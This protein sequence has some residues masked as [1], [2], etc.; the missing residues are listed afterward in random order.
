MGGKGELVQYIRLFKKGPLKAADKKVLKEKINAIIDSASDS[1]TIEAMVAPS[2]E[3]LGKE[4]KRR[5][6]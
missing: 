3:Y 4:H 6:G 1:I 2:L 5:G